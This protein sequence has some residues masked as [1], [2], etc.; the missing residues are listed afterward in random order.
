M[1]CT[2]LNRPHPV[3]VGKRQRASTQVVRNKKRQEAQMLGIDMGTGGCK[4]TVL[5]YGGKHLVTA[6]HEYPT[7]Y[8][9]PGWAEQD[10][11]KWLQALEITLKGVMLN[12][13]VH[14]DNI[15]S[16]GISGATHSFVVANKAGRPLRPA[17][18]WTDTRAVR[19]VDRLN[20]ECGEDIFRIT[21]HRPNVHWTL[22]QLLWLKEHESATWNKVQKLF[23]PKD[24]VRFSLTGIWATDWMDAHGTLL[25]NVPKKQWSDEICQRTG[26]NREILPPVFPPGEVVGT[27]TAAAAARFGLAAKIPVVTGTTDQAAEAL[28][29]GALDL[30]QGIIKCA[31][32]GNVAVVTGNAMPKPPDIYAYYHIVPHQ[33]YALTGTVCCAA[34]YRWLRDCLCQ[35]EVRTARDEGCNAYT[36]MDRLASGPGAGCNGLVF[37][38]HLQGTLAD[39]FVRG[40]FFGI[41]ASHTK[42]HFVRSVLEGVAFSIQD[43]ILALE[44]V[45]VNATDFKIIGGVASGVLW[46]QIVSDVTGKAMVKPFGYDSSYGS[47][48]LGAVG[49]KI[50]SDLHEA[51]T[52]CRG[53]E[54]SIEPNIENHIFYQELYSVY[55][56]IDLSLQ[57][58]F[59]L[60]A[61]KD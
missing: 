1:N 17:M 51:V 25:F 60:L 57:G 31:T 18:L 40:G 20:K 44:E 27:V 43:R 46:P 12:E 48:L 2:I 49:V 15:Q 29:A 4:V 11:E 58:A 55:K 56:D 16:I 7:V 6:S 47:A 28:A 38:P 13:N 5:D 53:R 32:A 37:Y 14:S 35:E 61:D 59:H 50:F 21:L 45:N 23:M 41:S 30:G 3:D 22:P 26:I 19:Q 34:C 10:P 42:A 24:Y 52:V 9:R 33:W 8:P 39:P 54:V 36:I